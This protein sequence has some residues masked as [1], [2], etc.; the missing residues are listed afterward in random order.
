MTSIAALT[1][2]LLLALAGGH[3]LLMR[4]WFVFAF[5]I[6]G[7]LLMLSQA[8]TLDIQAFTWI[9]VFTLAVSVLLILAYPRT[10]GRMQRGLATAVAGILALNILEAVVVDALAGNLLN[11]LV[12][13]TLIATQAG[14][15]RISPAQAG[16]PALRYDLPWSWILAY[17]A[18]NL[19]VVCGHYPLH[20]FDHLAVLTA[21]LLVALVRRDRQVWLEARAFTLSVYALAIVLAIDV[22]ALDWIPSAADPAPIHPWVSALA[23][24]LAAWNLAARYAARRPAGA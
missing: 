1:V 6:G 15:A 24:G 13:A 16:R 7:P 11:A 12:G 20:W 8:A 2:A 22:Y 18:W 9:K 5:F 23:A 17:T 21:P 3:A 19:T 14:P 10:T 4:P